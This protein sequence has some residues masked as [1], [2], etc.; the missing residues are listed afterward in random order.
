MVVSK[1]YLVTCV[2]C[3]KQGCN[4]KTLWMENILSLGVM[5]IPL[6]A[7]ATLT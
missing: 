2:L 3:V 7:L 1:P 6:L 4:I 5:G